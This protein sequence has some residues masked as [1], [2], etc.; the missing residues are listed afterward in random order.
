MPLLRRLASAAVLSLLGI[1]SFA[2][3]TVILDD[4]LV[5]SLIFLENE[6]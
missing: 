2:Q 6:G 3:N 1:L 4:S 5:V